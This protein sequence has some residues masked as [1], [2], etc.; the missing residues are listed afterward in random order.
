MNFFGLFRRFG[1][2]LNLLPAPE[3]SKHLKGGTSEGL[4]GACLSF[5]LLFFKEACLP[6]YLG[7]F[8]SMGAG[9]APAHTFAGEAYRLHLCSDPIRNRV[10]AHA[11]E[12]V[13][14]P[15]FCM[16]H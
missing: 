16:C 1:K 2:V 5:S 11:R 9:S 4:G 7:R 8:S 6:R 10:N 3:T 12:R 15:F 14:L 13:L